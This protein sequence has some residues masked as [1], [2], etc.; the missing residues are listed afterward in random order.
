MVLDEWLPIP[1]LHLAVDGFPLEAR[2][3]WPLT[4]KLRSL[5]S[6]WIK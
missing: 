6:E 2:G 5:G 4:I 1:K 3:F